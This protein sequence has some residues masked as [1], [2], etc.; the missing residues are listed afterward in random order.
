MYKKFPRLQNL[1]Q[2][3][4]DTLMMCTGVNPL[5][6]D[7]STRW[8]GEFLWMGFA[9]CK[10]TIL[11]LK[12]DERFTFKKNLAFIIYSNHSGPKLRDG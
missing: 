3:S 9:L 6:R 4:L 1:I 7:Y 10:L 5:V 11:K 12:G 2:F 8:G